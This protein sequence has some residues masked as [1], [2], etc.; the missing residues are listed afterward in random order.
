MGMHINEVP[1][2]ETG[3]APRVMVTGAHRLERL[4][5]G[6]WTFALTRE[7]IIDRQRIRRVELYLDCTTGCIGEGLELVFRNIPQEF[8]RMVLPQGKLH[9]GGIRH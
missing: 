4:S 6:V 7:L 2:I 5:E 9:R 8:G 3:A 1:L